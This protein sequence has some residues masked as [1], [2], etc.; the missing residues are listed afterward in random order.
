MTSKYECRLW[1][2]PRRQT[3]AALTTSLLVCLLAIGL[4]QQRRLISLI[5]SA[6]ALSRPMLVVYDGLRDN[7]E[8]WMSGAQNPVSTLG[9]LG[10]QSRRTGK[11]LCA[12]KDLLET[13]WG[14]WVPQVV[15]P[16]ASHPSAL[17]AHSRATSMEGVWLMYT[18]SLPL[19]AHTQIWS[20]QRICDALVASPTHVQPLR[21]KAACY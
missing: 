6:W 15:H 8:A 2:R 13:T 9:M 1:V 4:L 20:R 16:T 21:P 17:Q 14:T 19:S 7:W 18:A 5:S 12:A 11:R 10:L 3:M